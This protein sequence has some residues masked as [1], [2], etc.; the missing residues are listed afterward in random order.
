M[1]PLERKHQLVL[2]AL[3]ALV[4]FVIGYKY[5]LIREQANL[6][7][8]EQALV[9]DAENRV[10][11]AAEAREDM[12]KEVVVHVA[13]AVQ[14]PGVYRLPPGARIVDAVEAAGTTGDSALDYLNLAAPLED[15]KQ[16]YVFSLSDLNQQQT[17]GT[18]APGTVPP[19]P[20]ISALGQPN[21]FDAAGLININTAGLSELQELAGIGPSLAQRIID[22]RTEHGSFAAIEDLMLVSG[23]GDKRFEQ[24]K[25]KICV[26]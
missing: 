16:V 8:P 12:Q 7:P 20:G 4:L 26:H 10:G 6:A 2:L 19:L 14:K 11:V 13:G 24:I 1:V 25:N 5:A 18:A 17:G 15:G 23:I 3:A 21:G 9:G 22:Y